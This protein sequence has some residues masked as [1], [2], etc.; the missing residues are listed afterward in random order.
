MLMLNLK[1]RKT[2][3]TTTDGTYEINGST[4]FNIALAVN[5]TLITEFIISNSGITSIRSV[6]KTNLE[7]DRLLARPACLRYAPQKVI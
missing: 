5:K 6:T 3:R 2:K 4:D 7:T 1:R